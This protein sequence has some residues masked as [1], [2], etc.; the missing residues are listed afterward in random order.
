MDKLMTVREAAVPLGTTEKGLRWMI[1]AGT[2][3]KSA[4]VGGRR[5]MFRESDIQAWI[6]AQF[7][8]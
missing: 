6:D 4:L 2:A 5:R 7:K 8:D 1:Y 3:P